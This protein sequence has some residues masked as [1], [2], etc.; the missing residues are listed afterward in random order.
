MIKIVSE[1]EAQRGLLFCNNLRDIVRNGSVKPKEIAAKL[2]VDVNVVY[3]YMRG[4][5]YPSDERIEQLATILGVT[6]DDLFDDSV[7]PWEHGS[8]KD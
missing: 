1:E 5:Y 8:L 7:K 2:G 3:G 4:K 6:V